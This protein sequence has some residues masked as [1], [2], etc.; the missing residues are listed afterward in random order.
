MDQGWGMPRFA[1]QASIPLLHPCSCASPG[2][3]QLISVTGAQA[4]GRALQEVETSSWPHR[5]HLLVSC[6]RASGCL[7]AGMA[8]FRR[9]R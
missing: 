9:P 2:H 1:S 4:V 8:S 5:R 3:W 6:V 7:C